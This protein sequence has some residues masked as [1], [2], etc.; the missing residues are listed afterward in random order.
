MPDFVLERADEV[1][2]IDVPPDELLGRLKNGKVHVSGQARPGIEHF[3]RKEN[4]IALRE[5][6]LRRTAEHVDA[7]MQSYR[8]LHGIAS[9]WSIGERLLVCVSSSPLS[10]Q[11]I[12][13]ARRMAGVL[14]AEWLAVYVETPASHRLGATARAQAAENLRLAEQLGAEA[15]TLSAHDPARATIRY[16]RSRNVTKVVVGKP[17]HSGVLGS[18]EAVVSGSDRAR[19]QWRRCLRHV[20]R[21]RSTGVEATSTGARCAR[22]HARRVSLPPEPAAS[23]RLPSRGRYSGRASWPIR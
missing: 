10:A 14:H 18:L 15:V 8:Q 11:L 3:F 21:R 6:A 17:T 22:R 19:E 4:L 5:L 7:Q 16:A 20:R 12:R 23:W 1:R 2:L 13:G 9:T